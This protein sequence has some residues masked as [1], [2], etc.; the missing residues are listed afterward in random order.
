MSRPFFVLRVLFYAPRSGAARRRIAEDRDI[1]P[2]THYG[3][4]NYA[5]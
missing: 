4:G 1:G 5:Q 3:A 2:L